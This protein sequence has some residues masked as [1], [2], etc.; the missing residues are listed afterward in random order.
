[1]PEMQWRHP[2]VDVKPGSVVLAY[3]EVPDAEQQIAAIAS[4]LTADA[5]QSTE[6]ER[7]R[8]ARDTFERQH[9]LMGIRNHGAGR[10]LS[11]ATDRTWRLRYRIGDTYHHRFWGQ[12]V[13]WGTSA[14]LQAGG[15]YVQLGTDRLEYRSGETVSVTARIN[16]SFF[17]P[18]ADAKAELRVYRGDEVVLVQRLNADNS[19]PGDFSATLGELQEPGT[20]RIELLSPEAEQVFAGS[21]EAKVSTFVQ[22]LPVEADS[23]E[24]LDVTADR[25]G[26]ERI[27]LQT[28]G[29]LVDP[30]SPNLTGLFGEGTLRYAESRT[31]R[32]WDSWPLLALMVVL[33]A[34]EWMLRKKGGLV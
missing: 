27:A 22:V 15:E 33:L 30:G 14:K 24:L 7:L 6:E 34:A 16:D 18:I 12:I 19:H 13:R 8:L 25:E 2:V 4:T 17:A 32:L 26:L 21:D 3:A 11:L 28:G 23:P 29:G 31:V 1:V 10:V 20:Y 9:A 5:A